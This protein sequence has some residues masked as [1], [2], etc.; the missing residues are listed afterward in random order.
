[1]AAGAEDVLVPIFRLC[2]RPYSGRLPFKEISM[3]TCSRRFPFLFLLISLA[4]SSMAVGSTVETSMHFMVFEGWQK[5]KIADGPLITATYRDNP[6]ENYIQL[7]PT[8]V[9]RINGVDTR[10]GSGEEALSNVPK[11]ASFTVTYRFIMDNG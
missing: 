4:F 2:Y 7:F 10:V 9:I 8:S 1:M 6:A 3:R 11:N 5:G